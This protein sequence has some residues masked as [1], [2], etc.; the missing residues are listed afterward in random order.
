[1][2]PFT[3]QP[4]G[5]GEATQRIGRV[6]SS[7]KVPNANWA[8]NREEGLLRTC[9]PSCPRFLLLL[10]QKSL[11]CSLHV[12]IQSDIRLTATD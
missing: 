2:L 6:M 9:T 4:T 12:E 8:D 5:K 11:G 10:R 1:M 3:R 7:T